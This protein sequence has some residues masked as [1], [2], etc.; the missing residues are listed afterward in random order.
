[1]TWEKWST[2]IHSKVASTQ[3]LHRLL[4]QGL[5]FFI[6]LSSAAGVIGSLGQSNYAAGNTYQDGLAYHRVAIGEKAVSIDLGLMSDVGIVAE[7][8][9]LP[10]GKEAV[11]ELAQIR[12]VEFL[13]LLDRYC[14][15]EL[16]I[17]A[18]EETQPIL[19]LITPAQFRSKNIE[20]PEWL[21][22]RPIFRGL[23]KEDAGVS[24]S[25]DVNATTEGWDR[26]WAGEFFR[27]QSN[28]EAISIVTKALIQ[29]LAKAT[30]TLPDDIDP[31]RPLHTYGVDS[32]LAVEVRNWFGKVFKA[33]VAIFDITGPA[34]LDSLAERAA[35]QSSLRKLD[36]LHAIA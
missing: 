2:S 19:G 22:E 15:P 27:A 21:L 16:D 25:S 5:S 6:M 17:L 23:S 35:G 1:M 36:A 4:P 11:A 8:V 9:E 34:T 3:N 31:T 30:S 32:L 28:T 13:A 18:S 7:N 14:N 12:E 24:L 26:D 10:K 33:D 29:R 20:P